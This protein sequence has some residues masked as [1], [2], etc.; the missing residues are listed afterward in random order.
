MYVEHGFG[1]PIVEEVCE[2]AGISKPVIY[3]AFESKEGLA[4]AVFEEAHRV[5]TE[6]HFEAGAA[7]AIAQVADGLLTP[8]YETAFSVAAENHALFRFLYRPMRDAPPAAAKIHEDYFRTRC[9]AIQHFALNYFGEG[10]DAA[11]RA[12]QLGRIGGATGYLGLSTLAGYPSVSPEWAK[13]LAQDYARLLEQGI[14]N[15]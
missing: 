2:K 11:R 4:A 10:E 9:E 7:D 5:E 3:N 15:S 6:L 12:H 8:L 14:D 1:G 13:R